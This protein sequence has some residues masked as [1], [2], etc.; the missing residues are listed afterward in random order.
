[1]GVSVA[2]RWHVR[3]RFC[4]ES[5]IPVW[6]TFG[7]LSDREIEVL[8]LVATGATNQ[9]IARALV[10]S[11][12]TVKVHLRNIFEKLG[13]QSR[14]EA[15]MEAVRRGLVAVPGAVAP[16]GPAA[17]DAMPTAAE[18]SNVAPTPEP[19]APVIVEL[20]VA[21]RRPVAGWQRVYLLAACLAVIAIALTPSWWRARSQASTLTPLS[22][23]G[24]VQVAPAPRSD[25]ARWTAQAASARGTQP[26]GAGFGRQE[27]LRRGR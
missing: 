17:V 15:T 16:L 14:T 1:M 9:Q 25:V 11:P 8:S 21:V 27:A 3:D 12:N 24:Q 13:V 20:P 10:I 7:S 26:T 2:D 22:D 18:V 5:L 23:M 19:R 6:K 4:S